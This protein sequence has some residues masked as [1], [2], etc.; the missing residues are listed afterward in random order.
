MEFVLK[1]RL[2]WTEP[3]RMDGKSPWELDSDV[4]MLWNDWPYGIDE[5]IVS[6]R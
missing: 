5:K 6:S 2:G 1:K 3:I 4:K